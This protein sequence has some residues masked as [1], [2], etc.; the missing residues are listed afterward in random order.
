ML[1]NGLTFSYAPP[2]ASRSLIAF[3]DSTSMLQLEQTSIFST[4]TGWQLT[5]G[6]LIVDGTC[7]FTNSASVANEG[8]IFGDG[9]TSANDL[10]ITILA[11]SGI[12]L[13]SGFIN[14]RNINQ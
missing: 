2:T 4:A 11:E 7:I 8:F 6:T 10:N 13:A 5:K 9:I 1:D 3:T 12:T 14:Y